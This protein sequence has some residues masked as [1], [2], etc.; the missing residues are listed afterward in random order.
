MPL[1]LDL[2]KLTTA[3]KLRL[4]EDLWQNLTNGDLEIDS[5]SWHGDV[6]AERDR[7]ISSGEEQLIDWGVAKKQLRAE[8]P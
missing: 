2:E 1:T 8:L 6:L 3:D 7:L 5:P 4:M